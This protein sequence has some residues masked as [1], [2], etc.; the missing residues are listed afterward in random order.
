MDS[1]PDAETAAAQ[2]DEARQ[3]FNSMNYDAH[4]MAHDIGA[5]PSQPSPNYCLTP[6]KARTSPS[7]NE[8]GSPS[9][10]GLR[11][12]KS[13]SSSDG[14]HSSVCMKHTDQLHDKV[15][16]A[17]DNHTNNDLTAKDPDIE[18]SQQRQPVEPTTQDTVFVTSLWRTYDD[19]IILSL[20]S[21]LG[22]V[23]RIFSA[24]WFRME[25]GVVFSEDSALGTNLPLNCCSCFMLGLL[26]TG[27]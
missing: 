19:V 8:S 26:C 3:Q 4:E 16:S 13:V 21:M 23:F 18:Q 15:N 5:G 1:S 25:L 22:I 27:R 12:R 17:S 24:T 10:P 2:E 14:C 9:T 6:V 20:F 11:N 7:L